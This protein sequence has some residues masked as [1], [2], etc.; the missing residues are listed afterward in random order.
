M[1]L[2]REYIRALLLETVEEEPDMTQYVDTL[3]EIILDVLRNDLI[4]KELKSMSV[5]QEW[6][7]TLDKE[8][9]LFGDY[10]N[11]N[12]TKLLITVNDEGF[13]RVK[14]YYQCV[15][16]DRSKSDLVIEVDVFR[17]YSDPDH[18]KEFEE[19]LEFELADALSHE[20]QHS[21]DPS[22]MLTADIPEGEEKWASLD[23][24]ERHYTSDAEIRGHVAGIIGRGR[25]MEMRGYNADYNEILR[26]DVMTVFDEAISRG[27]NKEELGPVMSRIVN[28]WYERMDDRLK[29]LGAVDVEDEEPE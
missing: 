29:A 24:I 16:S 27:Y 7:A 6:P 8:G 19:W 17:G 15:P 21:C 11:I 22:D 5:E 3:L 4:K 26:N 13:G 28:K 2:L 10:E 23:H 25:R 14:G 18:A 12:E 1:N 20:L 9:K